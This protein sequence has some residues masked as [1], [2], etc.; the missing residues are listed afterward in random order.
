M[1]APAADIDDQRLAR[2]HRERRLDTSA[3][4]A[5]HGWIGRIAAA[6]R[7]AGVDSDGCN[8]TWN[9]PRLRLGRE[10]ECYLL[11]L[12]QQAVRRTGDNK[13]PK[14]QA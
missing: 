3:L 9:N 11:R 10:V 4:A 13:C 6:L 1:A 14:E 8:S 2:R 5:D 12:R 7:S